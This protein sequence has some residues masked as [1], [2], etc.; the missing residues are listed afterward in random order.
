LYFSPFHIYNLIISIYTFFFVL[1][2]VPISYGDV[3]L[4][5]QN[6]YSFQPYLVE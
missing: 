2:H 5:P 6:S 3:L 4:T 1:L